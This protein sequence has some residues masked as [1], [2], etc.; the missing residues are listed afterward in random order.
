MIDT[1]VI[2]AGGRS[3]RYS[4]TGSEHKALG[5]IGGI[6]IISHILGYLAASG[7]ANA[8][9]CI[10]DNEKAL[11]DYASSVTPSSISG[12]KLRTLATGDHSTTAR[13]VWQAAKALGD[14][15]FLLTY[16]DVL[17]DLDIRGFYDLHRH[18]GKQVTVA[19]THPPENYGRLE[20][21]DDLVCE[22]AEKMQ[23]QDQWINAGYF[24]V[25]S[26]AISSLSQNDAA[27]EK[28]PMQRLIDRGQLAGYRH[29]GFWSA[30]ETQKDRLALDRMYRE[31]NAPWIKQQESRPPLAMER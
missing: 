23:R 30:M 22:F 28:E 4:G 13:R 6:P 1:A 17:S 26:G 3:E 31:K 24:L 16:C 21:R 10:N 27:W 5:L 11:R 15:D 25:N 19:A 7:V 14:E 12:I 20:F 18:C 29:H 8:V 9:V 2:L